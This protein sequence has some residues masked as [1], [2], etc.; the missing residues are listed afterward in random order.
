M[1]Q[2]NQNYNVLFSSEITKAGAYKFPN[3]F[4][5]YASEYIPSNI[6]DIFELC[7]YIFLTFGTYRSAARRVIRYFLTDILL[8][9][10]SDSER[11]KCLKFL[12]QE[13][14]I[15]QELASIGDDFMV[16]GNVFVSV[17]FPFDRYLICPNCKTAY[18]SQT[19]TSFYKFQPNTLQFVGKCLKCNQEVVFLREDRRS[20]D[21][22]R[23]KI[24][25][26]NPKQI[27][28]RPHPLSGEVEYYYEFDA[29]FIEKLRE[30][31]LFILNSTPWSMVEAAL[32][33]PSSGSGPALFKFKKDAIYHFKDA[34]LSGLPIKGFAIPPIMSSFK[35]V[36]YL[37]M[38]RRYD[39][40]IALDFIMPFRVIF[41][42]NSGGA[43]PLGS[44]NLQHFIHHLQELVQNKRK[45]L[46]DIQF[47][48]FPI[49]YQL[50]GGEAKALAPKESMGLAL[51]EFLNSMGFPAELYKGS[52]SVQAFPVALRL[53]EKT[54]GHWVE[55]ANDFLGWLIRKLSRHFMWGN[56]T[57]RLRSVTLADDIERKVLALQAAAGMDISKQ[58][59][60]SPLGIDYLEEQRRIIEEQEIIQKLQMEAQA[61]AQTNALSA[62]AGASAPPQ[63]SPSEM[64]LM[65]PGATPGD[66]H[67]QAKAI[68]HQ[69][70]FQTP[71]TL[72]RGELIKIKHSNP[73]LHAL[74][75][76]NMDQIRQE[77]ARQGQAMLLQQQKMAEDSTILSEAKSLPS[78]TQLGILISDQLFSW[79]RIDLQKVAMDIKNNVPGARAAFSWVYNNVFRIK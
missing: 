9:G 79:T 14:K 66:V 25:R 35:L 36:Y 70:I 15:L 56:I 37:H 12:N 75:L 33:N 28:I 72:R 57:G 38:L 39:E 68:A 18:N 64:A 32:G 6:V 53:F 11:E 60:Y 17:Y 13:L 71:E 50:V 24:V 77:L 2:A 62:P 76:Q 8:E 54:W 51:D 58:T 3:P 63:G 5:D 48:P 41:P 42:T 67:E 34:T 7:E 20:P 16:Y 26:W 43:D 52:L 59:A 78:P 44:I 31:N 61:R 22:S 47:A 40:A 73:T 65:S 49:G 46:T 55:S 21:E 29:Q 23:V 19:N 27:K 1:T 30:G 69:L 45:N 4:F 10:E 74:V